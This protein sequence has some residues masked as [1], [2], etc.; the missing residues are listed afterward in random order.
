VHGHGKSWQLVALAV[1]VATLPL[2]GERLDLARRISF[3]SDGDVKDVDAETL[4]RFRFGD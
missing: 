1:E 2:L 4:K 3:Q